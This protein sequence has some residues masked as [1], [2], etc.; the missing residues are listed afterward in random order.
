MLLDEQQ[1]ELACVVQDASGLPMLDAVG[2]ARPVGFSPLAEFEIAR[3]LDQLT[4]DGGDLAAR[5]DRLLLGRRRSRIG[6]GAGT[7]NARRRSVGSRDN[8]SARA[9]LQVRPGG[10]LDP[11]SCGDPPQPE[12]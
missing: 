7:G 11:P 4:L 6:A 9:D 5:Q 3:H 1:A 10:R 8:R 2:A 12:G